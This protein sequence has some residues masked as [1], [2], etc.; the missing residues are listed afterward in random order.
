MALILGEL[1]IYQNKEGIFSAEPFVWVQVNESKAPFCSFKQFGGNDM[2][3]M[4]PYLIMLQP[5]K[6]RRPGSLLTA[7]AALRA[8]D[9]TIVS[10]MMGGQECSAV[11]GN[12]IVE[13]WIDPRDGVKVGMATSI[14]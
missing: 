1:N 11:N 6:Q 5:Q 4:A 2:P 12:S 8:G 3:T 14:S 10:M 13:E 9:S 7:A